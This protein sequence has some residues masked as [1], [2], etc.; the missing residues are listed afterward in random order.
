VETFQDVLK[1]REYEN[2]DEGPSTSASVETDPIVITFLTD[3]QSESPTGDPPR[4]VDEGRE[5]EPLAPAAAVDNEDP[6]IVPVTPSAPVEDQVQNEPESAA[7]GSKTPPSDA[8]PEVE[9]TEV[10]L[11]GTTMRE[12]MNLETSAPSPA[13]LPASIVEKSREIKQENIKN[14]LNEIIS[15]IDKVVA[16]DIYSSVAPTADGGRG[17]IN[18]VYLN[19]GPSVPIQNDDRV[20][21]CAFQPGMTDTTG[22]N[23]HKKTLQ[24]LMSESQ[25]SR[26]YSEV[27]VIFCS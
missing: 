20:Y 2:E 19:S 23:P 3:S 26:L 4:G 22:T 13:E 18:S 6:E 12:N 10:I 7:S 17:M 24:E 9:K 1:I 25:S 16:T 8:D 27:Q 15:E 14:V 5:E 21:P 11:N